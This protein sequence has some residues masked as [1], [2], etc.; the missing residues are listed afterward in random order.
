MQN[1]ILLQTVT[2]SDREFGT[3]RHQKPKN[4][5]NYICANEITFQKIKFFLIK[6]SSSE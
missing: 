3:Q 2:K 1:L 6:G 4:K 5:Q